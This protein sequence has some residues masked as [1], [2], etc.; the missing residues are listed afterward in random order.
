MNFLAGL[1]SGRPLPG[2]SRS[3]RLIH[4][5]TDKAQYAFGIKQAVYL[6]SRLNHPRVSVLDFGVGTGHSS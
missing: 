4:L 1:T 3:A 5:A 6:A 2:L